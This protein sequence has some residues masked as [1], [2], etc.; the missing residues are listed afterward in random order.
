MSDRDERDT[1]ERLDDEPGRGGDGAERRDVIYHWLTAAVALLGLADAVYLTAEHLSGR[2]VRCVVT[3]GCDV[4]LQSPY[5]SLAGR[6]P[7]ASLGALA[8]FTVFSLAVLSA[9]GYAHT[10]TLLR[11]VV[12]AMF[13]FTLWLFYL[14]A[15]VLEAFCFYC[16]VSAGLTTLLVAL[17]IARW[18]HTRKRA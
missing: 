15:Y 2:N 13:A 17:Q 11:I 6:V 3:T 9:F 5:A 7:L 4:V 1:P 12:A 16:L 18:L 10:G 14:Q 8:Y